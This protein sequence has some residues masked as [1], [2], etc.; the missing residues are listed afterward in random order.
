MF[1]FNSFLSNQG[2]KQ[3]I[4][5]AS[6]VIAAEHGLEM[7]IPATVESKASVQGADAA[8][9]APKEKGPKSAFTPD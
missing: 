5:T 7:G 2:N 6:P 1:V 4:K 3:D 9:C 8:V